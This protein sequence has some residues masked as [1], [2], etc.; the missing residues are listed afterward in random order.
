LIGEK[1]KLH[2]ETGRRD[3][4]VMLI[5]LLAIVVLFS[6]ATFSLI[7]GNVAV[8]LVDYCASVALFILVMVYRS[9]TYKFQCR[10]IGVGFMY[11]L[12]FYLFYSG[13]AYGTTYMWH[14]TFPF[15]AIF[16]L[17]T[18]YGTLATLLLFFPVFG[19]VIHDAL[20]PES[21]FYSVPFATRFIPS[22]SVALIFAYLFERERMRFKNQTDEAYREQEA[23]I[24]N[25]TEQL[26]REIADKEEIAEKLRQ[27]KKMEM[28]GTLASGVAHDLN[29]ILSGIVT[30]PE[31]IRL[32][33]P[34][35]SP[36]TK[37]LEAIEKAGKRAADVVNDLLTLA[38]GAASIKEPT[39]LHALI[40]ELLASPEWQN[41]ISPYPGVEV[42]TELNSKNA[43]VLFSQVHLRKCV[44]NLLLN[45]VEATYP[46]GV[47]TISTSSEKE[48]VGD[49][50]DAGLLDLLVVKISDQGGGI[51]T[52]HM[53]HIFEPFYTT[54]K[55]GRSGSG[56]GLSVVW[57]TIIEHNGSISVHNTLKGA[58]FILSLE[59]LSQEEETEKSPRIPL[60][61]LYGE[62]KILIVDDEVQ[63]AELALEIV[64]R[65]GYSGTA[66]STGEEAVK[67]VQ[68]A[69]FDI[70]L[71]DMVLGDGINGRETFEKIISFKPEQ[72][73]IIVSGYSTSEEVQK[74]IEL[75]AR[76]I[77]KKPY[78]LEEI[79]GAIKRCLTE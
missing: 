10:F 45:G 60:G 6:V 47:V 46:E 29:N 54:K 19:L 34:E 14:Y 17:G 3:L 30:Y 40:R 51:A 57:N 59:Q 66:V 21:G 39:D 61:K 32:D 12:Y 71:L 55:M 63:L 74:S 31:L 78:S 79:G 15:F 36:I 38:R 18:R 13:A 73:A 69:D 42:R 53:E 24:T 20:T 41:M 62:G 1:S 49:L 52:E 67:L 33:L 37:K 50:Q 72:K 28:I 9:T 35:T 58:E 56:L 44:M 48:T 4:L 22:V 75:G 26:Q 2:T 23:I 8:A 70:L 76:E 11:V 7:N 5:G 43:M 25:R 16:L 65:L 27:S 77:V 68:V 64:E